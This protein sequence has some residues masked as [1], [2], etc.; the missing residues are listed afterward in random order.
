MNTSGIA[1]GDR[2]KDKIT[3]FKGIVIGITAWLYNCDRLVIQPEAIKDGKPIDEATFDADQ[4]AL[5]K[6]AVIKTAPQNYSDLGIENGDT[7]KDIITGFEGVVIGTTRWLYNPDN[8]I[9]QPQAL[10]KDKDM[11]KTKCLSR[12]S[13]VLVKKNVIKVD[14]AEDKKPGGPSPAPIR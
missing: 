14:R 8:L 11:A 9:V 7:A 12:Q 4:C 5:V 3:G 10:D 1:L 6:K 13:L 2:A